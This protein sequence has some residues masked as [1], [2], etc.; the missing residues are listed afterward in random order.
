MLKFMS[1]RV[2]LAIPTLLFASFLTLF[3]IQLMPGNP[4][5]TILGLNATPEQVE[6][7][8]EE[9]GVNQP[10]IQQL[11]S[12]LGSLLQGDL[13]TS[14]FTNQPVIQAL[15]LRA[16]VTVS[17]AVCA[18]LL[19]GVAGI[20]IGAVAA[21]RG[22]MTDRVVVASSVA[23]SAIPNF[24]LGLILVLV[25]A[26]WLPLFPAT[27]YTPLFESPI[28]WA[29]G[30]TLGVIAIAV[31]SIASVA[32][33]TRSAMLEVLAKDYIRTLRAAGVP[34]WSIVLK[35]ALRNAAVTVV[36]TIGIQFIGILSG[37]IVVEQVFAFSGLGQLTVTAVQQHDY[38]VI[39]GVV[40]FT[41]MLVVLANLVVDA[42]AYTLN[43]RLRRS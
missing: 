23:L 5:L 41:T 10:F 2:L 31:G 7:L 25:F 38:P 33:Q 3:L 19:V 26:I 42:L 24:W 27:G 16:P 22:G 21:L 29:R 13:G 32:R 34:R 43:P 11:G 28:N 37:A 6:A 9:L 18:T 12:W 17:L 15:L 30:L 8:N 40:L 36:P 35:H 20:A 39:Q 1:L 14:I 4:A